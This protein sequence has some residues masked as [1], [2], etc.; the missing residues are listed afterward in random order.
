MNKENF[1]KMLQIA[2]DYKKNTPYGEQ[3]RNSRKIE[4]QLSSVTAEEFGKYVSMQHRINIHKV[5][6]MYCEEAQ[7]QSGLQKGR[8]LLCCKHYDYFSAKYNI[9]MNTRTGYWR[10]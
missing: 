10:V 3:H 2:K 7:I 9:G 1:E 5:D 4:H 8:Y 6:T